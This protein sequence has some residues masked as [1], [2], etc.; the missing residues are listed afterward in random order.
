MFLSGIRYISTSPP[1]SSRSLCTRL[2]NDKLLPASVPLVSGRVH[3]IITVSGYT[4]SILLPFNPSQDW[5]PNHLLV[6]HVLLV[7]SLLNPL[8]IP[9][10]FLY[11]CVDMS[12]CCDHEPFHEPCIDCPE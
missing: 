2:Q 12:E 11:F 7:F 10:A 5:L 4:L 6:I 3:L 8:V 1:S 9:F